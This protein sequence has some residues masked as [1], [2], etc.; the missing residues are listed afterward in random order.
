MT[1]KD[2]VVCSEVQLPYF[3]T[4]S[5][6]YKA[7]RSLFSLNPYELCINAQSNYAFTSISAE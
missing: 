1:F 4:S 7:H 6:Y 3:Y 5:T 2:E